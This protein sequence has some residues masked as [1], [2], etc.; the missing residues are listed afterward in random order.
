MDILALLTFGQFKKES[1]GFESGLAASE[2]ASMLIGD[3]QEAVGSEFRD[4]TGFDRFQIEPHTAATGAFGSRITIGKR[5]IEDRLS[6]IYSTSIGTNEDHMIKLKYNVNKSISI[7]GS[8]DEIG[9]A[10]V[11]LKYRFEFK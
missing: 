5:L 2:A 4:I 1:K 3:L 7:I 6:V 8:R 10:G 11:D 9:S